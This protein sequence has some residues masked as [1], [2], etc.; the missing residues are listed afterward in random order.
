V[1]RILI[2]KLGALGDFFM[3]Q[4]ALQA[5][6]NYH[7]TDHL[8]LLTIPGL[9]SLAA[10][11]GMFDSI[12]EDPRDAWPLGHWRIA[13][14]LERAGFM[15]TYDLQGTRRTAWYFRFLRP[16]RPVWAGPVAGC[17]LPRPPRP[18]GAHRAAWYAAQL[19]AL[20]MA[21]PPVQDPAWLSADISACELPLRY[22]LLA[23]GGS[24]HR[25]GKRWPTAHYIELATALAARGIA[26]VLIGTEID[27]TANRAI[28]AKVPQ[29]IDLTART[30]LPMLASVARGALGAVGNDTGPMHVIA[31]TGCA[32]VVL[33]SNESDPAFVSPLGARVTCLQRP[34]LAELPADL[35]L[36]A[37][38]Q[39][40]KA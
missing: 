7:R 33:Y 34:R 12:L 3:A 27:A 10:A 37:A 32:S 38:Q 23:A 28:A 25:P 40:W 14:R 20:G 1:S 30:S 13:R 15:R 22:A 17:A 35:V 6:R 2:I 9:R 39:C 24:A 31:A 29:A 11:S 5:I 8:S 18:P 16:P 4:P 26:P 19:T 36:N 21:V